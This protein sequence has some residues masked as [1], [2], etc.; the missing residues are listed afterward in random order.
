MSTRRPSNNSSK[1]TGGRRKSTNEQ[2]NKEVQQRLWGNTA[3]VKGMAPNSGNLPRVA[4][5][6]A[7]NTPSEIVR[8]TNQLGG[9]NALP[10]DINGTGDAHDYRYRE[11]RR[12]FGMSAG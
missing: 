4:A 10:T 3:G 11:L 9:R 12:A 8:M 1:R 6:G 2:F 7:N 5:S